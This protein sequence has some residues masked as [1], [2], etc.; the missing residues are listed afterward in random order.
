MHSWMRSNAN[1]TPQALR[2][3]EH[4]TRAGRGVLALVHGM[5]RLRARRRLVDMGTGAVVDK[6]SDRGFVS[7]TAPKKPCA[8]PGCPELVPR[9]QTRCTEHTTEHYRRQ[10]A[11][12]DRSGFYQSARWRKVRA[13]VL[14]EEPFC[15]ACRKQP[16]NEVDHVVPRA[17]GGEPFERGNL[18]GMCKPCHSTKTA[19]EVLN[20]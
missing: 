13:I 11:Q 5:R 2:S 19:M 14:S 15:R 12:R 4:P 18:Q 6:G 16:S 17:Q 3:Q 7:P 20:R 8:Q 9:T 10:D 1:R